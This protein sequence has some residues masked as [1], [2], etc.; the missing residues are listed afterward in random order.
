MA[1][2][3]LNLADRK[4]VNR[5]DSHKLLSRRAFGL[6]G[7]A[8]FGLASY[9]VWSGDRAEAAE[10]KGPFKK[11]KIV[12]FDANGKSLGPAEVEKVVKTEAEWKKLLSPS[13]FNITRK[14]D[15]EFAGSGQYDHFYEDGLYHCICCS[16]PLFDSKTKFNS[17]T[18]WPSFYQPIAKENV[19]NR[20][21]NS[22]GTRTE[23]VCTRCDAHLGHV[24]EDGPRPTGLRYCMNSASLHF[25]PRG[26]TETTE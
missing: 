20:M 7:V 12:Q 13:S 22:Y 5:G 11:V 26:K 17:G 2:E 14:Q 15:T 16:T 19:S 21:D 23:N 3:I 4:Q 18:G 9:R 8:G 6:V 1:Y 25:I 10:V 24:F